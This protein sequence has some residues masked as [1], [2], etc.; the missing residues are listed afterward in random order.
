MFKKFLLGALF[1]FAPALAFATP[2][3]DAM[4]A[5]DDANA[6]VRALSVIKSPTATS[7]D[8]AKGEL[9]ALVPF[10]EAV[11]ARLAGLNVDS[12]TQLL[13]LGASVEAKIS[14]AGKMTTV[15]I[16]AF[17]DTCRG[18]QADLDQWRS[19][20]SVVYQALQQHVDAAGIAQ[21]N[22]STGARIPTPIP[23]LA[24]S[25]ASV[26]TPVPAYTPS[27]P[28]AVPTLPPIVPPAPTPTPIAPVGG[29]DV[30]PGGWTPPPPTPYV[31][32]VPGGPT[33]VPTPVG[34]LRA[35]LPI[36]VGHN[37]QRVWVANVRANTV[38]VMDARSQRFVSEI[39]VGT[40]PQALGLDDSDDT[41]VVAN[42]ASNNV[43]LVDGRA[44]KVLK[45]LAVGAGPLQVLVIHS[46]KAYVLCQDGKSLAVIDLKLKL[47]LKSIKFAS[48]P[49]RMDQ[50]NSSQ[51]IYVSLPDED[52]VA[53]VD[54][55]YDDVV[56]T[57]HE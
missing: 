23:G 48:R 17:I 21:I 22:Q 32:V 2:E 3:Q 30:I 55:S 14:T 45:T 49:G 42:Y 19:L 43:S 15:D 25:N 27:F 46:G 29:G 6:Q 9:N 57:I 16:A 31:T 53:V 50:P 38:A 39:P 41:L 54:T 40:Q 33:P 52:S 13:S 35:P 12:S 10:F 26:P 20:Q 44:D 36:I 18:I 47:V 28:T 24:G 34:L 5:L 11:K 56:A 51:N 1:V 8:S 4:K 7:I 37:G